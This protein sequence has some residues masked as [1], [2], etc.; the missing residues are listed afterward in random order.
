MWCVCVCKNAKSICE[1]IV[2]FYGQLR[3]SL[4]QLCAVQFHTNPN[5][6]DEETAIGSL[7]VNDEMQFYLTFISNM[8]PE[9]SEKCLL[10]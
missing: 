1:E 7:E 10:L 6:F 2:K 5:E 8:P 9:L 3:I 4:R